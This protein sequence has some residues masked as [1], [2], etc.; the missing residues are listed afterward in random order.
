MKHLTEAIEANTVTFKIKKVRLQSI[1]D[2]SR[3]TSHHQ[4]QPSTRNTASHPQ[5]STRSSDANLEAAINQNTP[6]QNGNKALPLKRKSLS[7]NENQKSPKKA[8]TFF[9]KAPKERISYN[10]TKMLQN[11]TVHN[12]SNH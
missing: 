2:Q 10:L 11:T 6:S 8:E 1:L 12:F 7:Y 3:T 4:L 5:P 9:S